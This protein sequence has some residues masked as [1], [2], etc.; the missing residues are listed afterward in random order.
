MRPLNSVVESSRHALY[1]VFLT[2]CQAF[3]S[4][5]ISHIYV[6][7]NILFSYSKCYSGDLNLACKL[8]DEM[9]HKDTVTWNT[10]ITG[11]VESGNLGAAW[12][13]LKSMKR[14]GFQADGYTFGSILKGVAHACRH[15]LGQQ[16]HSLIVKIGYEQSVYAGSALLDMYA[17]CERVEDAYNVFQGMPVRNFVSWNA[18]IDGFVQVGDRDT[19]FWLLDCMQKE[20]VR[21]EDGTFAPLLTLLDGDKFYKLTMQLH[22]KIIKHGLEFYNA[23]CNAT[24]T[25]YS[26]CGLLEDAKRVFDGAVV[27]RDLVTWNSMLVAYLV[28]DKD[29]DAFN[30]FL[31]MQGFGFEPDIYTYTCVISACFAAAHKKYGKSFHAL[32][33]KRGLEESVT[34]CNA[35]ITMYLKLNNKSMEAAL[36]LFHSMK[37]KDRVSWNSILTGFSQMGFSEDA[38]KLFGHMRS[39]L[40]EIDDYAYSA[41]LRSCSDL[42]ILQL[43]QQIHLLTVKTGFDLNDFVA[44]SLIFMYSKCGI[45]EDAWKCFEDTTKESSITW[46]SI[47]FAY[48]QHGQGDVALDLFSIMRER[49]VKLDHVTFVAVLTACSHI[50][51]VEQGRCFLKSMASDYGIPP[52]MEHYACAVD[53]F[54]RAGY[55]EEAKALIDSM[56][57]QPNAMVLKTLLGACR[58]CG[59]IELAAQVASQLL[60]VEPEEHCTYVILSNMYGHL[61]RWDDKASVTRLMRERKVKKVPGWSWIEVKNEVHA[62][63]AEDRSHPYSEDVYQILGELME[64]MTRLHSLASSDSLMHDVNHMYLRSDLS[65]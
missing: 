55:L 16:V 13:F 26:E 46:N 20:G 9:P 52:R 8:F 54:G 50:G 25:A 30:L 58:A 24:L 35:L 44:S 27:T 63:K 29:E 41:V 12:E 18:L 61:K 17:K 59:N 37:S 36:K 57:F 23:L 1:N 48:A 14:R 34:I 38:L 62:F 65:Y 5:I 31:E 56:P 21:V 42:A 11:Y 3:K 43:G 49:E 10:M 39:S 28:H 6:A 15:D 51:L 7:N 32:V 22:C 45:I 19:A 4:G 40:E 47:M 33:I 53:L 64:E 60:E 2:H